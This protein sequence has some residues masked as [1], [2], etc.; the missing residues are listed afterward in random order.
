MPPLEPNEVI[1]RIVNSTPED[2]AAQ[3]RAGEL[4]DLAALIALA[5]EFRLHADQSEMIYMKLLY[6]IELSDLWRGIDV[7]TYE[8][9]LTRHCRCDPVRYRTGVCVFQRV[10]A[11]RVAAISFAAAREIS[12]IDD[13]Q[14]REEG[15]RRCERWAQD[16]GRP[17]S[18]QTARKLADMGP[19]G[20]SPQTQRR[21]ALEAEN[22][23]LR[24]EIDRLRN[25]VVSLGGNPDNQAAAE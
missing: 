22:E 19:V 23:A 9:F 1:N 18:Q 25:L 4:G 14:R 21:Q 6:A 20:A 8:N 24:R 13:A 5:L 15:L 11:T 2:L 16:N 7:G 10:P 17:P 3:I 12:K